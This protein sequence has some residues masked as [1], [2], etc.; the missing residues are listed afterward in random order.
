MERRKLI[1]KR[2]KRKRLFRDSVGIKKV[3][4]NGKSKSKN[5]LAIVGT[6]DIQCLLSIKT[7]FSLSSLPKKD[8]FFGK[9]TK[10][11]PS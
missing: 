8:V 10:A 6:I 1:K 5:T 9:G 11:P 7:I 2:E 3:I 4:I